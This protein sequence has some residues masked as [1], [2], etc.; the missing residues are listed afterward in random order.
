MSEQENITDNSSQNTN[1]SSETKPCSCKKSCPCKKISK[2]LFWI[3]GSIIAA[4]MLLLIFRDLYIPVAVS[5]VGTFVLGTKV[6][7]KK[8]SSS[9]TGKVDIQ[10][11]TVANPDGYN[12]PNAF[13]LEHVYVD[14]SILSLL[15]DEIRV[16]EILVTGM[17]VDLEAKLN[18]TNL[19]ELKENVDKL[20]SSEKKPETS[21]AAEDETSADNRTQKSVV[22]ERLNINNNFISL[23]NS[24]IS[25]TTKIP[26]LPINMENVGE[27]QS[28]AETF[29]EIFLKIF[30]SIF[31]ACSGIGG[32]L[33]DS[34]KGAAS[35]I[36]KGLSDVSQQV[37]SG[38]SNTTKDISKGFSD[39]TNKLL[40]GFK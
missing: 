4:A 18:R 2:I 7:L 29:S 1:V 20:I 17:Q 26:L 9:L 11:L 27:G 23:S 21:S 30:T 5:K 14:V 12:N 6:E 3:L 19:G 28:I 38:F 35:T 25:V 34:I 10:N 15:T 22:I 36:G 32:A 8:F 40:K 39:T 24:A 31:D 13:V 37:G 16:K 33:G